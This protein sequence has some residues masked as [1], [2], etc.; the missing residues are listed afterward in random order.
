VEA[1]AAGACV[2]RTPDGLALRGVAVDP[3]RVGAAVDCTVRPEKLVV[4]GAVAGDA[5]HVKGVVE[6]RH[7]LGDLTRH[8]VR[9]ESGGVLD[10]KTLNQVGAPALAPG[11]RVT[12]GWA[13]AD[14]R[15]FARGAG[16]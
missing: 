11:D 1:P 15:V 8:R 9:L 16:A 12:L 14:T 3:V 13:A 7:Y 2:V 10:V 5:N 6:D 4:A